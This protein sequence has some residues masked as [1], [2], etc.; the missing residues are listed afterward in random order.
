[1]LHSD[2]DK[3]SSIHCTLLHRLTLATLAGLLRPAC[4]LIRVD[5]L[6]VH[7]CRHAEEFPGD[8]V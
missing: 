6:A 8:Q 4:R 7:A 2:V 3:R 1:M 5:R